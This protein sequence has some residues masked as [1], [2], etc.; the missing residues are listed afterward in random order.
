M[1]GT[2]LN[3]PEETVFGRIL[4]GVAVSLLIGNIFYAFQSKRLS[5]ETGQNHVT[6]LP[7]GVNTVSLFAF[8]LFVMKPVLDQT[9]DVELAW[10]AGLAAC[11][12]SGFIEF[13]GAFVAGWVKRITPRAALLSTLAGIAITFI[14]MYFCFRIFADP[15]VSFVPLAFILTRYIGH[16]ALPKNIPAGLVAVIFGILLSWALGRMDSTLLF[17][18]QI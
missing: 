6:A 11:F 10:K 8:I 15:L 12:G 14:A 1:C 18:S 17:N 3:M 5:Q 2:I 13:G 7:F 4:P 16:M 9:H